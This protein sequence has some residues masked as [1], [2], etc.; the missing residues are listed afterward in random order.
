MLRV[1]VVDDSEVFARN[2]V[3]SLTRLGWEA[4]QAL[5]GRSAIEILKSERTFD[6]VLL[7]RSM[8]GMSGDAVLRWI[9]IDALK[10]ER[11]RTKVQQLCVV[12]LTGYGEV[13]NAVD[14]LK[15]GAFQYLEKPIENLDHL[16]S[17]MAAGIAWHRAHAMRRELL[18]TPN[19]DELF[20]R[21]RSILLDSVRPDGIHIMF[22]AEDG[23]I[24]DIVGDNEPP[25]PHATPRFVHRLMTGE[26]L[27][28]EQSSEDVGPL[29]PI[30]PGASAL[31]AVPVPGSRRNMVG[32]LDMESTRQEAF[33]PSWGEVL[34]Y[35]ADLIGIALEIETQTAERVKVEAE[36]QAERE[37]SKQI[38]LVYRELRHSIAT[39][40]QI[41]AMQARQLLSN[42]LV[43]PTNDRETRMRERLNYIQNNA[44]IIEGVV[45]DIKAISLEPPKPKLE[46]IDVRKVV[47]DSM[48]ACRPQL[49]GGIDLRFENST[50]DV[51]IQADRDNLAYCLKCLI[52]NSVEAIDEVR[53]NGPEAN[54]AENDRIEFHFRENA[55]SVEI[56]VQDS[57]VGFDLPAQDLF[58]PLF[59]TKT[60][61]PLTG[62]QNEFTGA[63]RVGR[64]LELV[65][66]WAGY[67][68][69]VRKLEGMRKGVDIL[70]R[71]GDTVSVYI[72]QGPSDP[73]V[74]LSEFEATSDDCMTT[75]APLSGDWPNRGVGLYSV[76]RIVEEMHGGKITASSNGFG[77]GATFTMLLPKSS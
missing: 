14:A 45:Q 41:V 44:D 64:I 36:R 26:Q 72:R 71:D 73:D 25:K 7:D 30:L 8:P 17:V 43:E 21:V 61:R 1:L 55:D 67:K 6:G 49:L 13:Q 51:T 12:M 52:Q 28:F 54:G 5:D 10:D 32:V 38:G 76:R 77:K 66:K 68:L 57:G 46:P 3:E 42:D 70:I 16:R 23:T 59:S 4:E 58:Q 11:L 27:V 56:E 18:V 48:E 69:D 53:R 62:K 15:I 35:L 50:A 65:G 34:S 47:L 22:L 39:H 37:K 63:E 33:D 31:M 40:A 74:T 9:R 75:P 60:R 29:D 20:K 19:R 24:E 2:T